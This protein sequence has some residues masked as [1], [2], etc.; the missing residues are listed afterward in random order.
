VTF[1]VFGKESITLERLD[2]APE[3]AERGGDVIVASGADPKDP[4][5]RVSM[6]V[7]RP[8]QPATVYDAREALVTARP[9][10]EEQRVA[11]R[12]ELRDLQA[13]SLEGTTPPRKSFAYD[14]SVPMPPDVRAV[15]NNSYKQY[16]IDPNR[17][18]AELAAMDLT[19][20]RRRLLREL[21]VLTNDI[22]TESNSRI[23]FALS[24]VV[25]TLLGCALGMMFRSGNFL[26]AFAV[27][28]VPA[29][30]AITLIV[31]GQRVGG[32]VPSNFPKADNPIQLGLGLIWAGNAANLVLAGGLWWRLQRQ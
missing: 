28:F 25:L 1:D 5:R 8:G 26:T 22:V 16:H 10:R 23:S 32:S 7:K 19:P 27:S 14:F 30:I 31:A 20:E 6:T 21:T 4:A 2:G 9:V 24:C 18:R 12:I 13:H 11:V 17:P 15:E 29:L 3:A